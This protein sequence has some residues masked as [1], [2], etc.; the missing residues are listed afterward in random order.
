METLEAAEV[1][2]LLGEAIKKEFGKSPELEPSS[3]RRRVDELRQR[4]DPAAHELFDLC[5]TRFVARETFEND[6]LDQLAFDALC[7][8]R[9]P[10]EYRG[11]MNHLVASFLLNYET[12][13][14]GLTQ[15]RRLKGFWDK[16]LERFLKKHPMA[17]GE[18]LAVDQEMKP[19]TFKDLLEWEV[20]HSSVLGYARR[21]VH[22][23]IAFVPESA[24]R[25]RA[26]C[27]GLKSALRAFLDEIPRE[28]LAGALG[29][30]IRAWKPGWLVPCRED[31][32]FEAPVSTGEVPIF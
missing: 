22:P 17:R 21:P 29:P 12:R 9:F 31:G 11:Q 6:I 20:I 24:D 27:R 18:I 5:L 15:M 32:T 19:R 7:T 3:L 14:S 1:G 30:R 26:R 10:Q 28:E 4:V 25:L 2:F 23:V 13:V 8:Y 16:S